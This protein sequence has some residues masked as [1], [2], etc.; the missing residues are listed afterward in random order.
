MQGCV[1]GS[2]SSL[3]LTKTVSGFI[4]SVLAVRIRWSGLGVSRC[5]MIRF[6]LCS[7]RVWGCFF[8]M[9]ALDGY[10]D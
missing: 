5:G 2:A 8:A 9:A 4:F 7:A 3:S 10:S 6:S 1:F